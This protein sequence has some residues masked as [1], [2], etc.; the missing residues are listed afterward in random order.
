MKY[1]GHKNW[2]C[3]N[4]SLWV[5]NDEWLYGLAL[6]SIR[7]T[8]NRK[9][10]VEAMISSLHSAGIERTP[11]GALYSRTSLRLAMRDMR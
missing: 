4:V 7:E 9:D 6:E 10:A 8:S 2:N 5:N 1:N 11:D 3:W